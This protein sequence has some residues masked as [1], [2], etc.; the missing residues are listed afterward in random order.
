MKHR[1]LSP[2]QALT[3]LTMS[4]VGSAMP[5]A[6]FAS[7]TSGAAAT[8]SVP[9][10]KWTLSQAEQEARQL[11]SIPASDVVQSDS[12]VADSSGSD[13]SYNITFGSS[14]DNGPA[15]SYYV[16]V[17]AIDG[18][19]LSYSHNPSNLSFAF[20]APVDQSQAASIAQSWAEKLYPKRIGQVTMQVRPQ[21]ETDLRSPTTYDFS[22]EREVNGVPAPFDGFDIVIDQTGQLQSVDEQ[23]TNVSFPSATPDASKAAATKAYQAALG[24]H[25]EYDEVF[26]SDGSSKLALEYVPANQGDGWDE[27]FA[28]N[29]GGPTI[30]IDA[31]TG[32][33]LS[34][35]GTT[36]TPTAYT[37]PTPLANGTTSSP[38]GSTAV[39]WTQ[40]QALREV[41]QAFGLP[42]ADLVSENEW[43]SAGSQTWNFQFTLPKSD[44]APKR[45]VNVGVDAT[46]GYVTNYSEYAANP[47]DGSQTSQGHTLSAAAL[48]TDAENI[49]KTV[50]AGHLDNLAL[51]SNADVSGADGTNGDNP[52]G[53]YQIVSLVNG[54]PD[55]AA[56]GSV[57]LN[58]NT[59]ELEA[60]NFNLQ[61]DGQQFP[62]A[63]NAV[64]LSAAESAYL[65]QYPLQLSYMLVQPTSANGGSA[66]APKVELA[67]TPEPQ[68]ITDS[69][70]DALQGQFVE[71][72]ALA[73][74]PYTGTIK[75]IGTDPNQAQLQLL[76]SR[77]L[78]PVDTNGDVHP[79][80]AMTVESFVKLV[81]DA[82]GTV[83]QY[84]AATAAAS[85]QITS[86][87]SSVAQDNPAYRELVT[88]YEL[89]WLDPNHPLQ[90][91][92][93]I[94]RGQAAHILAEALG[95]DA[96]LSHPDL[97]TFNPTDLSTIPATDEAA[98]AIAVSLGLLS[99]NAGAFDDSQ[100]LTLSNAAKAVVQTATY[101]K[102]PTPI[103]MP[104]I[105]TASGDE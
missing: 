44:A 39:N 17:D 4:V 58:P 33:Y 68:S 95:Y 99:L 63:A 83:N 6:A 66:P 54:I 1:L 77:G 80:Q 31:Q 91:T 43:E 2:R 22:F 12:F 13:P 51:V 30:A 82:L 88:A 26:Q 64:D 75:D 67:Y 76:A 45:T 84:N 103:I 35:N 36:S 53:W 90:P 81:Q 59:G 50:Y 61:Q 24:L 100:P 5:V 69:Y 14:D 9:A 89:G 79:D 16:N 37:R 105:R 27:T 71:N 18:T 32:L 96:L 19:I 94:T 98:D 78:I 20:P 8:A 85:P 11:F 104:L 10:A 21:A 73:Y 41:E 70:F 25:L 101:M 29:Q 62:S 28:V 3:V 7:T 55:Q 23:W 15:D 38:V 87:T 47:S 92:A 97:F 56:G 40:A 52:S 65:T 48:E 102:A 42:D 49:V 57:Q 34:P 46:Y 74:Q 60:L 72:V 86:A 93:D